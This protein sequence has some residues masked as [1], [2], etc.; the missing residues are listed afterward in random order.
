MKR[1]ARFEPGTHNETWMCPGYYETI[2]RF[3]E[4]VIKIC[5]G[6]QFRHFRQTTWNS[7]QTRDYL[8]TWVWEPPLVGQ[9]T[10]KKRLIKE[11]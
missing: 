10:S 11:V 3:L 7:I 4:E 6:F 9:H 1:L 8:G 2:N 5:C